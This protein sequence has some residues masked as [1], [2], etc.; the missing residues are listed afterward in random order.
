MSLKIMSLTNWLICSALIML[1]AYIMAIFRIVYDCLEAPW[2]AE[3]IVF[4]VLI[5]WM[6]WYASRKPKVKPSE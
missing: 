6:N 4:L 2:I 3:P 1:F 5:V